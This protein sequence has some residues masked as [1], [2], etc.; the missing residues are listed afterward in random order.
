[1]NIGFLTHLLCR[2]VINNRKNIKIMEK[3]I[4]LTAN[5]S[6]GSKFSDMFKSVA[7]RLN[8]PLRLLMRYY[9]YALG[10]DV[11]MRQTRLL[12]ETQAAFF[13]FVLPADY[14]LLLRAV[15]CVWFVAALKR[16]KKRVC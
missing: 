11:D 15:A 13:L 5:T 7:A 1:M 2:K 12:T 4:L 14:S 16:C 9:S 6:S 10:R 8:A 3:Q